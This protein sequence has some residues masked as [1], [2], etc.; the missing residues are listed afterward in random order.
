ML[1]PRER[2]AVRIEARHLD[3]RPAAEL[4]A[5]AD[6]RGN[7]AV[8]ATFA[9]ATN[10][11]TIESVWRVALAARRAPVFRVVGLGRPRRRPPG[12]VDPDAPAGE[13]RAEP[14]PDQP[15]PVRHPLSCM[16]P[17]LARRLWRAEVARWS[18]RPWHAF[19]PVP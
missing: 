18:C 11:L 4:N 7:T 1:R 16:H 8:T 6:V 15:G 17:T 5:S 19:E 3:I 12:V 13:I 10:T 14:D 2:A 9:A